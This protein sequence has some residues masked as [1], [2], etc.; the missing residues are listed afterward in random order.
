M[1]YIYIYFLSKYGVRIK[2]IILIILR[3]ENQPEIG[4]L[5]V[6]IFYERFSLNDLQTQE[7]V[8]IIVI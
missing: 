8:S 2:Y 3:F 5:F 6:L 7:F 4:I 1:S